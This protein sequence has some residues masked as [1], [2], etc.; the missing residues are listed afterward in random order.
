MEEIQESQR[1][2]SPELAFCPVYQGLLEGQHV[3]N[4]DQW[5]RSDS[6]DVC[7]NIPPDVEMKAL[8]RTGTSEET[9]SKKEKNRL[10]QKRFRDRKRAKEK[11]MKDQL[12]L[13]NEQLARLHEQNRVLVSKSN[14]MGRVL[15]QRGK[16][17]KISIPT[18]EMLEG[19]PDDDVLV[20][21]RRMVQELEALLSDYDSQPADDISARESAICK[22]S[23]AMDEGGK[24]SMQ[25]IIFHPTNLHILLTSTL[26][27]GNCGISADDKTFWASIVNRMQLDHEQKH[28]IVALKQIFETRMAQIKS[29]RQKYVEK[30]RSVTA[31]EGWQHVIFETIKVTEATREIKS[32]MQEHRM[33]VVELLGT[34]FKDIL[35]P[36]QTARCIAESYPFYPDVYQLAA[37]VEQAEK[38]IK[39]SSTSA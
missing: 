14:F 34:F 29:H 26:D 10:A 24:I 1:S 25:K 39:G 36:L 7:I 5:M 12:N 33:C 27:E 19:N 28:Q 15:S 11:N 20:Y 32:S 23:A 16:N 37:I 31:R 2:G 4:V 17:S 21:W 22:L 8:T 6:V 38:D 30:L 9:L 35:M 3:G 18:M 13:I